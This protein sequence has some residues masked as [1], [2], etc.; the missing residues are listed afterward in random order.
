MLN[1]LQRFSNLALNPI[2]GVVTMVTMFFDHPKNLLELWQILVNFGELY[3]QK[4][5]T[6][7]S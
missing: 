1:R 2:M 7:E 6:S 5:P 3:Q 4:N